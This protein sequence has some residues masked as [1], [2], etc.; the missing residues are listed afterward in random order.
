MIESTLLQDI[1]HIVH[2]FGTKKEPVPRN[3]QAYWHLRPIHQQVHGTCISNVHA[4]QQECGPTDGLTTGTSNIVLAILTADCLPV[5]FARADGLRVAALH[6]GWR[7][8]Y[9]GLIERFAC[10]LREQ[11]DTPSAWYAAIG[12]GAASCCYEVSVELVQIF[13]DRYAAPDLLIEPQPR[14]LNTAALVQWQLEQ[15]GFAHV[16]RLNRCTICD[17]ESVVTTAASY[18]FNSYR[19]EN[20]TRTPYDIQW[21]A[22]MSIA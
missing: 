10:L 17:R 9:D 11:D 1:P 12:P 21:S 22:I 19:R 16:D 7:G 8:V 20:A 4:A 6:L 3:L 18:T 5:L 13:K 15:Q 2:G 14:Y